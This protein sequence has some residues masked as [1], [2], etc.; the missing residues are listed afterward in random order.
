ML[1]YIPHKINAK[2]AIWIKKN[3]HKSAILYT[4]D[5]IHSTTIK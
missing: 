5:K 4:E 2:N 3:S 1:S